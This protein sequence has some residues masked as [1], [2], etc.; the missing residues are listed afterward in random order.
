M[1]NDGTGNQ[2]AGREWARWEKQQQVPRL[3]LRMTALLQHGRAQLAV[4]GFG[5]LALLETEHGLHVV[6]KD[7]GDGVRSWRTGRIDRVLG[8]DFDVIVADA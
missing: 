3:R 5:A 2:P 8:G 4:S 6:E 7:G 1:P